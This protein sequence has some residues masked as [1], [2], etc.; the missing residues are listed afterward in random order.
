MITQEHYNTAEEAFNSLNIGEKIDKRH[1]ARRC[2]AVEKALNHGRWTKY[3]TAGEYTT[4]FRNNPNN[5]GFN[6]SIK[7]GQVNGSYDIVIFSD[8]YHCTES[9]LVSLHQELEAKG[10]IIQP[11]TKKYNARR[12]DA[13]KWWINL[14]KIK[15]ICDGYEYLYRGMLVGFVIT[16]TGV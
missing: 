4:I 11:F 7:I 1:T 10:M 15:M 13:E 9:T 3:A 8:Q 12:I 6:K 14:K 16:T 5:L 2:K